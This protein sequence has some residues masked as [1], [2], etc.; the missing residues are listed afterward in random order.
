M[1][2]D[3]VATYNGYEMYTP[4][5]KPDEVKLHSIT[6]CRGEVEKFTFKEDINI[7]PGTE[8]VVTYLK[9]FSKKVNREYCFIVSIAKAK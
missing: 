3:I 6:N 7:E 4:R 1:H 2:L 5:T 8:C 9:G